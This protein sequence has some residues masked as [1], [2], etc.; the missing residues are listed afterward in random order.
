MFLVTTLSTSYERHKKRCIIVLSRYPYHPNIYCNSESE[1]A[2][3]W[4][5][6]SR[7][8]LTSPASIHDA[9]AILKSR[10]KPHSIVSDIT[11]AFAIGR[12]RVAETD[13]NVSRREPDIRIPRR[14]CADALRIG[15]RT[16]NH[17]AEGSRVTFP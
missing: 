4:R 17:D 16:R 11:C 7:G 3:A 8:H 5:F 13:S 14:L 9:A 6:S 12:H 15:T 10:G 1:G 2:K